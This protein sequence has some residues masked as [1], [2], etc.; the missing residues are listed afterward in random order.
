MIG[1]LRHDLAETVGPGHEI[2]VAEAVARIRLFTNDLKDFEQR[3]VNDIQQFLHETFVDTTWPT[4]P[5][6]LNH[7]L[8]LFRRRWRC[9]RL[10]I[11]VAPFGGL[12]R[13]PARG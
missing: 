7:P 9:E 6:H 1:L 13:K 2:A 4:C 8:W 10:G 12:R 11:E 5:A 3:V